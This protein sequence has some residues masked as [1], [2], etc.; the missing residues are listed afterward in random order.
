MLATVSAGSSRF[1]GFGTFHNA[2]GGGRSSSPPKIKPPSGQF[3]FAQ[4]ASS[5]AHLGLRPFSCIGINV[6]ANMPC[7]HYGQ[8]H[9][10]LGKKQCGPSH[11]GSHC[12]ECSALHWCHH[13]CPQHQRMMA[14]RHKPWLPSSSPLF[15]KLQILNAGFTPRIGL[16]GGLQLHY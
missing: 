5:T 15:V 13:C 2:R 9:V 8:Q 7:W 11:S 4:A 3:G 10:T 6:M 16:A 12:W 14:E 1:R